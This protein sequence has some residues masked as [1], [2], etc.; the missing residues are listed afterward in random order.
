MDRKDPTAD[1]ADLLLQQ[2]SAGDV[3]TVIIDGEIVMHE[4]THTK[5][6]KESLQ[7]EIRKQ[8]N[9]QSSASET[10][11]NAMIS[12]LKPYAE[13]LIAGSGS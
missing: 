9:R 3:S 4:R 8:L 10:S 5:L 11:F 13:K 7:S 12:E 1:S 6:D 2:F